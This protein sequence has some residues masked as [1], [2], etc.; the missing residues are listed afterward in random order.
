MST[1]HDRPGHSSIEDDPVMS[2]E[3]LTAKSVK[4]DTAITALSWVTT[5]ALLVAAAA[6]FFPRPTKV[7]LPTASPPAQVLY[8][9]ND[10]LKTE[11]KALR[12]EVDSLH[13]V[14]AKATEQSNT[15]IAMVEQRAAD[16]DRMQKEINHYII[17]G[18][19]H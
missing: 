4:H 12:A 1:T 10:S 13:T 3:D 7:E 11:V 2:P 17:N 8:D 9:Q 14:A 15:T 5:V 18:P 16:L 19:G 6:I